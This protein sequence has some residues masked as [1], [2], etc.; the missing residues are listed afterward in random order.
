MGGFDAADGVRGWQNGLPGMDGRLA[1]VVD[2]ALAG[3]HNS[4]LHVLAHRE[5]SKEIK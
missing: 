4:I 5:E 3:Q 2:V 1:R